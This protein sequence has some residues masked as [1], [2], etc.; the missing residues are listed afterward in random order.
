M[1]GWTQMIFK[2]LDC[3]VQEKLKIKF[4]LVTEAM[5]PHLNFCSGL[6][7]LSLVDFLYWT[8]SQH[9]EQFS[10]SLAAFG[11]T[12]RVKGSY[13]KAATSLLRTVTG[14]IFRI[15]KW[16]QRIKGRRQ[17]KSWG[18]RNV[19]NCPNLARAAAIE[20]RF[21]LN[22]AVVF[23]FIYFR[24]RPSKAKWIGNGL[25]NRRNAAVRSMFFFLLYNGLCLL[26]HRIVLRH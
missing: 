21:S 7:S 11:T 22:F 10:E 26:T 5:K 8:Y 13:L 1:N 18:V 6:P 15:S 25:P 24:F 9:S 12:F 2:F 17:W 14:R 4:L 20:V 19:S 23:D 3:F 16:N